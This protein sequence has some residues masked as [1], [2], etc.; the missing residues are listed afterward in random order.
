MILPGNPS[1]LSSVNHAKYSKERSEELAFF[2]GICPN[3]REP[4]I[5][6]VRM[7][8]SGRLIRGGIQPV[9]IDEVNRRRFRP[10]KPKT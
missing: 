2:L 3:Q 9:V 10:S 1:L 5:R 7:V 6:T 4:S 8:D